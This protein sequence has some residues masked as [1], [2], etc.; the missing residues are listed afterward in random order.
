MNIGLVI[1]GILAAILLLAV[2]ANFLLDAA[3]A[4]ARSRKFRKLASELGLECYPIRDAR[5]VNSHSALECFPT[6]PECSAINVLEGAY[7]GHRVV[8]FDYHYLDGRTSKQS[9][10]FVLKLPR[11]LGRLRIFPESD[12]EKLRN[13]VSN[14][15]IVFDSIEFSKAFVV[16]SPDKQFAYDV[17]H[18][19][20]MEYLLKNKWIGL[21]IAQ[22]KLA[23]FR[24]LPVEPEGVKALFDML[25]EIRLLMPDYVFKKT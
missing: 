17:C 19:R 24:R 12:L 6:S 22:D 14:R 1:M 20:M 10:M 25:V 5:F 18:G 11:A 23:I 8:Y 2:S 4:R 7:R 16:I 21:E 13:A 9:S 15:D 3:I